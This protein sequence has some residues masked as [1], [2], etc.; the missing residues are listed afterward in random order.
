MILVSEAGSICISGFDDA[1]TCPLVASR[2]IHARAAIVGAGT[3][4]SSANCDTAAGAAGAAAGTGAAGSCCAQA[5]GVE[6]S[7]ADNTA[8]ARTRREN[9]T[10]GEEERVSFIGKRDPQSRIA[11]TGNTHTVNRPA[12]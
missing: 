6:A 2:V 3:L 1:S 10:E 9:A 5:N 11:L 8:L 12:R 4:D 7:I